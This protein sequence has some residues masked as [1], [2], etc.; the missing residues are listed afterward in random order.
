MRGRTGRTVGAELVITDGLRMESELGLD[1]FAGIPNA[2]ARDIVRF[3]PR[4]SL[5]AESALPPLSMPRLFIVATEPDEIFRDRLRSKAMS[6][7]SDR[8]PNAVNW[9][10]PARCERAEVKAS[11]AGNGVKFFI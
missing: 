3:R 11:R 8:L 9:D 2:L 6:K 5:P 10:C 7:S 1:P 4:S